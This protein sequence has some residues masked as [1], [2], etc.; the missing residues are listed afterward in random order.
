MKRCSISLVIREIKIKRTMTYYYIPVKMAQLQK[1]DRTKH[2]QECE[3]TG[4][5]RHC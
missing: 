4:T 5:L 1:A 2:W 3:G